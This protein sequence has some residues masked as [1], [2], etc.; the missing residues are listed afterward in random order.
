MSLSWANI[1]IYFFPV[2]SAKYQFIRCS[3]NIKSLYHIRVQEKRTLLHLGD[4]VAISSRKAR[5]AIDASEYIFR[6]Y[7]R[8]MLIYGSTEIVH[9]TIVVYSVQDASTRRNT[10]VIMSVSSLPNKRV[11]AAIVATKSPGDILFDAHITLQQDHKTRT[12]L[13]HV[14]YSCLCRTTYPQHPTTLSV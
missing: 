14:S 6:L 13:L 5:V 1:H 12:T 4:L 2:R 10:P 3:A 11:G 7:Q 8:S 9:W